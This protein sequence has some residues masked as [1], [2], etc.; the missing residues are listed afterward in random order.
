MHSA[1]GNK[2]LVA[3]RD[4]VELVGVDEQLGAEGGGDKLRVLGHAGDHV[5]DGGAVGSV[6]GLV[7]LVEQVEGRGVAALDGKDQRKRLP[8]P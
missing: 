5:G 8:P 6:E 2:D 1:A 7:D 3:E 4:A